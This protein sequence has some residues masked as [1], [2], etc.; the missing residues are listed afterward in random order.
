MPYFPSQAGRCYRPRR[1]SLCD[2]PRRRGGATAPAFQFSVTY[3]AGGGGCYRPPGLSGGEVLPSPAFQVSV[4]YLA[5]GEGA[6][7][8][9]FQV[10]VTDAAW[11]G[12][13]VSAFL[14][15]RHGVIA[16]RPFG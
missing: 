14:P 8:P 16:S 3:L 11:M 13:A 6:T 15:L 10:S 7:A 5:G 12:V 9:A 4:T 2:L 1:F